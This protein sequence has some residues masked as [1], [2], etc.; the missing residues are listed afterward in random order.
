MQQNLDCGDKYKD[1]NHHFTS[2]HIRQRWWVLLEDVEVR[3]SLQTDCSP[4][5]DPSPGEDKARRCAGCA[6]DKAAGRPGWTG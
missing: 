4:A 2:L 6:S 5:A 1:L 3:R